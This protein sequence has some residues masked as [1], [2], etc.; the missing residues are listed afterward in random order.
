MLPPPCRWIH[1]E[2]GSF[3]NWHAGCIAYVAQRDGAWR[4]WIQSFGVRSD[5][6]TASRA[7][8]VRFLERWVCARGG[9][10]GSRGKV[11]GRKAAMAAAAR[12][13]LAYLTM[14]AACSRKL[15]L[16]PS[17]TNRSTMPPPEFGET[18]AYEWPTEST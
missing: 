2:T 3:L 10:P 18:Q 17:V 6:R 9:M 12:R 8:G 5:H 13:D 4:V 1:T 11:E 7:Q 15:P 14:A 16:M